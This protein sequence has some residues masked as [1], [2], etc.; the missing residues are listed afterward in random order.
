M[1]SGRR[2]SAAYFPLATTSQP[3]SA[4]QSFTVSTI[5]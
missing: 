2:S 5:A 3:S 4:L 1:E